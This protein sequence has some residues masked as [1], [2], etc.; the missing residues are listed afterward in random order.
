MLSKFAY[1]LKIIYL[2]FLSGQNIFI[3]HSV[4]I[5][6]SNKNDYSRT[7][8]S[9]DLTKLLSFTNKEVFILY[10]FICFL[11]LAPKW[12]LTSYLVVFFLFC[13]FHYINTFL[14]NKGQSSCIMILDLILLGISSKWSETLWWHKPL[15]PAF[16]LLKQEK[17]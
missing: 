13:C 7:K 6:T 4:I 11:V 15:N 2:K 3:N 8:Y 10:C 9:V 14:E 1:I 5:I 16:S 12:Y 17:I